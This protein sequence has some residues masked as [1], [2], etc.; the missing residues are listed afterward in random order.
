MV[1]DEERVRLDE[2]VLMST[3]QTA[4][5]PVL[6]P[7]TFPFSSS[8]FVGLDEVPTL[9]GTDLTALGAPDPTLLQLYSEEL[10]LLED[11]VFPNDLLCA[12]QF[13][14]EICI[15]PHEH[16][17]M[18]SLI[19]SSSALAPGSIIEGQTMF[20]NNHLSQVPIFHDAEHNGVAG[21]PEKV[22]GL[23][24]GDMPGAKDFEC[25]PSLNALARQGLI[26]S[27]SR[28]NSSG[29]VLPGKG[30]VEDGSSSVP[31]S[32]MSSKLVDDNMSFEQA[33]LESPEA[34][35]HYGLL[36]NQKPARLRYSKGAAPSKYCHVC[37]RSARTVP[38]ALCGNNLKGL[39]RKVVCD[40]CLITHEG[41]D[42]RSTKEKI[43]SWTCT[44]CRGG[45][46]SRA[47]CHQYQRNNMKR[48]LK[49]SSGH[50]AE[51]AKPTVLAIP[52]RATTAGGAAQ[53]S[54]KPL[55]DLGHLASIGT[56]KAALVPDISPTGVA[57]AAGDIFSCEIPP[58]G[59]DLS[60]VYPS[61]AFLDK[62]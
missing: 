30:E 14:D 36:G 11:S 32:C 20:A 44:H 60:N 38:V 35:K 9:Y 45:C 3:N 57:G 37:G 39:C 18:Q 41:S 15:L 25:L 55:C 53:A 10:G 42:L 13:V 59:N 31:S 17:Q 29:A 19:P 16:A 56:G 24:C 52:P 48:R 6:D 21:D 54:M 40:K 28:C 62:F 4:G 34:D 8:A 1:K 43:A 49:S 12:P 50:A 61:L 51:T 5:P 2:L 46:P 33:N 47:R 26:V 23:R 58:T 27:P 7:R 22:S